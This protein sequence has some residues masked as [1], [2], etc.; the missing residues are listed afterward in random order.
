MGTGTAFI[1]MTRSVYD[2]SSGTDISNPRQQI[3]LISSYLDASNVY[4]DTIE[5]ANI[6]RNGTRGLLKVSILNGLE[7]PPFNTNDTTNA[8]DAHVLPV[9]ILVDF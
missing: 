4:G 7:M 3:N 8:N 2:P 6:L 9:D 5:R 1:P